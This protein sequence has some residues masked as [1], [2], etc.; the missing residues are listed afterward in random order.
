MWARRIEIEVNHFTEDATRQ[1]RCNEF[2]AFG[3]VPYA[4]L[5]DVD[6]T[7]DIPVRIVVG[8]RGST[9]ETVLKLSPC[10]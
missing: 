2:L 6:V 3:A 8:A 10:S 4:G 7:S 1:L 9:T 5:F